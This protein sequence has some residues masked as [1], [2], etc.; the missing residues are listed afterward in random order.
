MKRSEMKLKDVQ[1]VYGGA[2]GDLWELI[3]GE[4]IHVGGMMSSMELATKAGIKGGMKGCDLCCCSGAGMRF[5][6]KNFKTNMTGVDVTEKV[7]E[8]GKERTKNE[9]LD[10][11][12][13]FVKADV[14]NIPI[15]DEKFDFVWG[16]DAW[17]YV[18]DKG[19]LIS[20][21]SRILKKGGTIAFTDWVEGPAG[22]SDEEA[23]RVNSFMKFPYMESI[24]GYKKLLEENGFEIKVAEQTVFADYVD[25]YIKML[26]EQLTYDAL[27]I[28]G[29]D[30]EL[31]KA[32]GGEMM[33]MSEIAHA[34]KMTRG[35]FVAVKK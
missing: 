20:E 32:M 13:S 21:A 27:K 30:M 5:L 11:K 33:F 24:P 9:G 8:Q 23:T 31:F 10:D 26:T 28:I 25:F 6:A 3:M 7:I 15:A 17:C 35:R 19:K 14:T 2:E 4:Q 22:M 1:A 16:E 12:V 29:D 34:D 18:E